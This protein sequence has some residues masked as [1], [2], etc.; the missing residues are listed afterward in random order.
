ME[1]GK[2]GTPKNRL[3]IFDMDGVLVDSE[4]AITQAAIESL[5]ER[6]IAA[7]RG[8]FKQFTGMGDDLFIGGVARIHGGEYDPAMKARAYEI[9]MA[10]MERVGVFP[11]SKR[12]IE[13]LAASGFAVAVASA[14]DR[15]KVEANIAAVG[16]DISIFAVVLTGSDVT[17]K[18]PDPEI[19]AKTARMAGY[20]PERCVVIEDAISGVQAARAAG[21]D[22]VA[23][24]TSFD[25]EKL[26]D[27]GARAAL[28]DVGAAAE[29][30]M[31]N[32]D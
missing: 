8:D 32:Y 25:A 14:S 21:M 26:L 29:W 20:A 24:L 10:H 17:R 22:C 27:A 11:A 28:A 31:W 2:F 30:I 5:A 9:Y 15:I 16:V 4:P 1:N 6:G 3:V 19:F 23:V 13:S 12:A 7:V 18:K